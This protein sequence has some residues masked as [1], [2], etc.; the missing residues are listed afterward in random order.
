MN[1]LNTKT[2]RGALIASLLAVTALGSG[3]ALARGGDCGY[4]DRGERMMYGAGQGSPEVRQQRMQQRIEARLARIELA[5]ALTPEQKPVWDSFVQNTRNR[6]GT[7][8]P[9]WAGSGEQPRTAIE[10]MQRIEQH[11]AARAAEIGKARADVEVLYA[12]FSDAQKT[13]FDDEFR[14]FGPR[15]GRWR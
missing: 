15:S 1:A 4:W 9:A 3:A 13:V 11:M 7:M 8:R 10:R 14:F 12:T 6:L 2:A 5:L